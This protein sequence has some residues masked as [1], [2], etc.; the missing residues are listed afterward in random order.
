MKEWL[1]LEEGVSIPDLDDLQADL[2][3]PRLK[4]THNN[5]FKL[6][7]KHEMVKRKVRSPD[8]ADAL[9]LTFADLKHIERWT[10]RKKEATYGDNVD[11]NVVEI[12]HNGD[13]VGGYGAQSWMAF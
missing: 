1:D 6:E 4:P 2:I 5:D 13:I 10:P 9:A 8:L 3:G 11:P 12:N 7:S